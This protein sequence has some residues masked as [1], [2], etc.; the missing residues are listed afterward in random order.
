MLITLL[1]LAGNEVEFQNY[2]IAEQGKLS[3]DTAS[4]RTVRTGNEFP[5]VVVSSARFTGE[6]S[7]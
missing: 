5:G 4:I 2:L 1:R 6:V 7:F 3:E